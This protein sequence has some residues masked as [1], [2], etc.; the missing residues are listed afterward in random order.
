M[1][2]GLAAGG[3][4][5]NRRVRRMLSGLGRAPCRGSRRLLRRAS[6]PVIRALATSSSAT[7]AS[8]A[9][10][11]DRFRKPPNR[12]FAFPEELR[13]SSRAMS[14]ARRVVT[15]TPAGE[16]SASAF[17]SLRTALLSTSR[18][19]LVRLRLE[20]GGAFSSTFSAHRPKREEQRLASLATTTPASLPRLLLRPLRLARRRPRLPRGSE[21]PVGELTRTLRR[22]ALNRSPA[23]ASTRLPGRGGLGKLTR[24]S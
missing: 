20:R 24:D 12:L 10:S 21:S 16:G 3:V 8:A 5:P 18:A 14:R 19:S 1:R 13:R 7:S 6:A 2:L 22:S 4:Y 11:D 15:A 23:T 9:R 17:A